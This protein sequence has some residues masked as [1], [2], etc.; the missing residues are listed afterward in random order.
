M[1]PA[2]CRESTRRFAI[3]HLADADGPARSVAVAHWR[4]VIPLHTGGERVSR[5]IAEA[6]GRARTPAA[7]SRELAVPVINAREWMDDG[8]FVDG[9]H[10]SRIGA[11]EFTRKLGPAV[12]AA[13]PGFRP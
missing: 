2:T 1:M 4:G 5:G 11:G 10:L 6:N 9:F 3:M 12:A 13:F 8:L 7:I